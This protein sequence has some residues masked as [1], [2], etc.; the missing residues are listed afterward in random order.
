MAQQAR[1]KPSGHTE[2]ERAQFFAQF[3]IS[4]TLVNCTGPSCSPGTYSKAAR[5][6]VKGTALC[7]VPGTDS[8]SFLFS[9]LAMLSPLVLDHPPGHFLCDRQAVDVSMENGISM[10]FLQYVNGTHKKGER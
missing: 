4:A 7:R 9:V 1:P 5:A 8:C 3:N 10:N 2:R 6:M